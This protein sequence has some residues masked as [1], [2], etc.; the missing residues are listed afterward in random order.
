MIP[1]LEPFEGYLARLRKADGRPSWIEYGLGAAAHATTRADC[2]RSKVGAALMEPD[3]SVTLTG[4]NGAPAGGPSC[5]LGECPR[6][7]LSYEE[8]EG[9]T[10]SYDTGPGACVALH[11]EQNVCLRASWTQM[12]GSTLFSTREPCP[13]CRRMMTGTPLAYAIWP[14]TTARIVNGRFLPERWS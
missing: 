7:L 12:R 5:L 8:I 3:H 6:G 1:D 14:G 9:L 4:Y 13:G 11:A 2:R 10:T